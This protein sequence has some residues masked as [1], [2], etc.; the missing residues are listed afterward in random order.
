MEDKNKSVSRDSDKFMLRLPDGMRDLISS[1]SREYGRSM[2]SEIVARLSDSLAR[3]ELQD[4]RERR[5]LEVVASYVD[6]C[7]ETSTPPLEGF[8]TYSRAYMRAFEDGA[9]DLELVS[10]VSYVSPQYLG[11]LYATWIMERQTRFPVLADNPPPRPFEKPS[12]N[13]TARAI[14]S[15]TAV[16]CRQIIIADTENQ[17]RLTEDDRD[18]ILSFLNFIVHSPNLDVSR[19]PD[20]VDIVGKVVTRLSGDDQIARNFP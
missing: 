2:N 9:G 10:G 3:P 11:E 18:E 16:L 13:F 8:S 5:K 4:A 14:T 6:W 15:L 17:S 19:M 7:K 12:E 1:A 20:L